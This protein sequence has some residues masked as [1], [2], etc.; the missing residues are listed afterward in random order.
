[1]VEDVVVGFEDAV[2]EPIVAHELPDVLN[3]IELGRFRR[4]R[5]ERDVV[6]DGKPLRDMPSR[7]I[8]KKDGVRA[9]R[10]RK[11]DFLQMKGHGFTVAGGVVRARRLFLR[12]GRWRRKYR[13]NSSSGRA[14]PKAVSRVSPIGG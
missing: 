9:G 5:Q 2:R 6:W 14:A 8:K 1:M 13:P 3:R 11:R 4:Q 12:P 10:D 7:L